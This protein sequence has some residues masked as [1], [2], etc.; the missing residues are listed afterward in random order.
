MRRKRHN[1]RQPK[2][3]KLTTEQVILKCIKV[4]FMAMER[5]QRL[6]RASQPVPSYIKG[7]VFHGTMPINE[8]KI[9]SNG[10][11]V[12]VPNLRKEAQEWL[13]K[14]SYSIDE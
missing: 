2:R 5:H 8:K 4:V 1:K 14:K 7:G 9:M 3:V 13:D 11:E 6:I 12:E 10:K